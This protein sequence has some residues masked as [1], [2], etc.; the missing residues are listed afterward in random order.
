VACFNPAITAANHVDGGSAPALEPAATNDK[1][2]QPRELEAIVISVR[3]DFAN[4]AILDRDV[5]GG[6][7][8]LAGIID[9]DAIQGGSADVKVSQGDSG[10]A[11]QL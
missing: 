3:T 1:V 4:P 6:L 8:L 2:L 5:A 7:I 10:T 9:I 11:G